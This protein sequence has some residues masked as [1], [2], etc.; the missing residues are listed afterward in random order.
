MSTP[1]D[2]EI[3]VIEEGHHATVD[4]GDAHMDI[5]EAPPVYIILPLA[6]RVNR[7]IRLGQVQNQINSV[8]RIG[9]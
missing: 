6:H 4:S 7:G 1:Y 8:R 5:G 3:F 2:L 9:L